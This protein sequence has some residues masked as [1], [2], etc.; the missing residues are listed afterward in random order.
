MASFNWVDYIFLG[1]FFISMMA[2]LSRGLIKEV[3]SILTWV[4]AILIASMFSSKLAAA[5]TGSQ[6]VQSAISNASS[7]IGINPE[8]S[9]SMLSLGVSF[10]LIFVFVMIIGSILGS[11]ISGAAEGSGVSLINRALGAAFGLGRGFLINIL[12]VFL[13]QLSPL[14]EQ[15]VWTDSQ[16]VPMFKPGAEFIANLVQPGLQ[17]LKSKVGQTLENASQYLPRGG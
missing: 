7:A 14:Q 1:V 10:I 4:A 8:Q 12:L 5:F 15:S 16:L 17:A 2:G 9:F 11:I 13:V 3:L 6:Q